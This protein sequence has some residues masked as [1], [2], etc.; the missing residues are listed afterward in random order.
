MNFLPHSRFLLMVSFLAV[1]IIAACEPIDI[2][3]SDDSSGTLPDE[4][5]PS[6]LPEPTG[7]GWYQIYFTNPVCP[8]EEERMGGL[9]ELIAADILAA[10]EQ[11][12]VASFDLDAEPIVNALIEL[13]ERGIP[14][15]V[16]TDTDN[17]DL[18]SIRRL[19]RNGISVIE[20]DR[21]A[22]MHNK[23]V[24]IDG[25]IL[26]MGSTNLTS[27]DIYCYNNNLARFDSPEL[28]ANYL[29]EVAEM[30][31]DRE[32][33]PRSPEN[34]PDPDLTLN[35]IRIENYF[36]PETEV[37]PIIAAAIE[38]AQSEI[39]FMAFSFTNE[40]IGEAMIAKAEA[41]LTVQGVFETTGSDTDFSYFPP[42]R[43]V[44][45][46]NLQVRQDGN[47]RF[48]HHK[49]IIID[50]QTVI[51]GS[52]N[53]TDSANDSNDENILIVHDPTFASYFVEEFN[54]VWEE[55]KTE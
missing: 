24:V 8:P 29:T 42:M 33:G 51:F 36:A 23:I 15:R 26:W 12:D 13:E 46:G 39:L 1:F 43:E 40:S 7:E 21:S 19:R 34:T 41:G 47:N 3:V 11:V 50:R 5:E 4:E 30:Y 38:Q 22:L 2:P 53:F 45:L 48:M 10:Q 27:N 25:R 28:V 18:S 31:D 9:D 16:V 49:V 17:A 54:F 52:F 20:D 35:G 55:A 37:A 14:V 32:F 6:P 44:E